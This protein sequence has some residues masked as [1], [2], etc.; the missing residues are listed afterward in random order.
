VSAK[1]STR[2]AAAEITKRSFC[3]TFG[4]SE[5]QLERLFQ[6]GMPHAKGASR[7]V[8][9]PMPD[10][11]VWYHNYLVEKGK[12]QAAPK[13]LDE[14]RKRRAAADADLAE[15]ELAKARNQTMLVEDHERML[16]EAFGRVRARL[17]N[18][19]PRAAG[20]A[21]GAPTLQE[22]QAKIEPVVREI[23]EELEAADD[24]PN[25]GDVE[26]DDDEP[27]DEIDE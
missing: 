19:A 17:L 27:S 4:V 21:F 10:G 18:L 9:I 15:L 25:A 23:M 2:N 8:E 22:C 1:S 11:R 5:A 13:D 6:L 16:G 14:A 12:K 24:V 3:D 7:R 20:A 26:E